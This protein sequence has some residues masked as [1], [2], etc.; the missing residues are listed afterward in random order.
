MALCPD[1]G[2]YRDEHDETSPHSYDPGWWRS[3]K[4]GEP[5]DGP[6]PDNYPDLASDAECEAAARDMVYGKGDE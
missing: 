2:C 1:R 3:V 6:T 4:P 5:Y